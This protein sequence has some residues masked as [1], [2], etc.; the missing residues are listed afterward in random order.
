VAPAVD[1]LFY[2]GF[3]K[4]G[5]ALL[6]PKD[7]CLALQPSI[8]LGNADWTAKAGR[9]QGRPL[10]N[11][12][13]SINSLFT[14]DSVDGRCGR[15]VLPTIDEIAGMPLVYFERRKRRDPDF[16]WEQVVLY[17]MDLKGAF[18]LLSLSPPDV[19]YMGIELVS[20]LVLIFLCGIFGWTSTP[21]YFNVL[22]RAI[23]W[24]LRILVAGLL[25][26]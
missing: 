6:L 14:K 20:G 24:E 7:C 8:V 16:T 21:G 15:I 2:E 1:R 19:H 17:K 18:T 5:L 26:M 13:R 10:T 11:T 23:V 4:T 22:S 25:V 3:V 9:P 12:K